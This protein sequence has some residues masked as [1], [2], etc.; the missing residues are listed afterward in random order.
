MKFVQGIK[1]DDTLD[2]V[3]R[4][5]PLHLLEP[6]EKLRCLKTGQV[7]EILTDYDGA[8]EDIPQWCEKCGQEF[9]GIEE[10]DE[11]YKLYIR[12]KKEVE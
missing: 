10:D 5:C 9:I 1:A 7:L 11:C 2:L 6:G 12:K 8:L 3:C 4:M